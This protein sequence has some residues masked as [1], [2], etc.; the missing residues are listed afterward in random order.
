M[1]GIYGRSPHCEKLE[2]IAKPKRKKGQK[3]QNIFGLVFK[4]PDQK[5][6]NPTQHSIQNSRNLCISAEI[7]NLSKDVQNS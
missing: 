2:F 7:L 5:Y 6:L 3:I 4:D 1:C